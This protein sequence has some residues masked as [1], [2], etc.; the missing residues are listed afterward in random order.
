MPTSGVEG[1]GQWQPRRP[2]RIGRSGTWWP[3]RRPRWRGPYAS[4]R[5]LSSS[6]LQ[7]GGSPSPPE[8]AKRPYVADGVPSVGPPRGRRGGG[9]HGT[10]AAAARGAA[11]YAVV[12]GAEGGCRAVACGGAW[13]APRRWARPGF[14]TGG[15]KN[16]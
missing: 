5:D 11:W 2:R 13:S 6:T 12:R 7:P 14:T 15:F 4:S 10:G 1:R 9:N 3:W 8:S 16:F